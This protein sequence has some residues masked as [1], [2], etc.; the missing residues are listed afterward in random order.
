[1]IYIYIYTYIYI[2]M[3][4][5]ASFWVDTSGFGLLPVSLGC[6]V[7]GHRRT[8]RR[9]ALNAS[10]SRMS[11]SRELLHRQR[12]RRK[13]GAERG[14]RKGRAPEV[15]VLHAVGR[16]FDRLLCSSGRFLCGMEIRSWFPVDSRFAC[17]C[18]LE[19]KS[20]G[21][22]NGKTNKFIQ[23]GD[24]SLLVFLRGGRGV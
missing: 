15:C 24:T 4:T 2:Y 6:D 1:M 3:Y 13:W 22:R 11:A 10:A 23:L 16:L 17:R 18:C 8:N 5:P 21:C 19:H 9:A 14:G 7:T 12:K 20:N